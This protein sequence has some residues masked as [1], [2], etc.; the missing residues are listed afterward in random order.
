MTLMIDHYLLPMLFASSVLLAQLHAAAQDRAVGDKPLLRI[1][2]VSDTHTNRHDSDPDQGRYKGRLDQTIAQVNAARVDIVLI[3]GDLTQG[4]LREEEDDFASQI[5]GFIAPVRY[6]AG[7]HDV[8][9]KHLDS[10]PG[11]GVTS[12]RCAQFEKRLG[13]NFWTAEFGA[14]PHVR[15][16]GLN[17]STLGSGL[18][19]EI[20]QWTFL[21]RELGRTAAPPTLLLTH[22][23]LYLKTPEEPGG[24]YWNVEPAPRARLLGL[25]QRPES[26]VIGVLSGHLHRPNDVHFGTVRMVTTPPVSFGLPPGK[27]PEGWTLV[28]VTAKG[29]VETE[30]HPLPKSPDKPH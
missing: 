23:P 16:I 6:V 20:A 19:E 18:P 29:E 26:R 30:F 5:K 27:Q 7:N 22:Y 17:S 15:V 11:A 2:L 25:I 24:D 13:A 10:K 21:E 8:G 12:A 3:A 1:A 14:G 4:G 28:T 9:D